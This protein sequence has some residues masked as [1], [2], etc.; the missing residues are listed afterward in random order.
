MARTALALLTMLAV[1]VTGGFSGGAAPPRAHADP[2]RSA[3]RVALDVAYAPGSDLALDIYRPLTLTRPAAGV[4]LVHGGAWRHGSKRRMSG[5]AR[6]LARRGFAVFNLEYTLASSERPGFRRQPQD[7]QAALRWIRRHAQRLDVDPRRIGA[8]GSSAGGHLVALLATAADRPLAPAP[9]EAAVVWSAPLDLARF[10]GGWLDGAVETFIGC[11]GACLGR[12]GAASPVNH[13][14]PGDAP[15]LLVNSAHEPVPAAQAETMAE[16][17]RVAQVPHR[18]RIL[19]GSRHGIEY[20]REM[21]G[22]SAAFLKRALRPR[23]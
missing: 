4:M 16:R 17:L 23:R 3:I 7:L 15:M 2:Q 18:L 1:A 20:A 9:I 5:I 21:V 6:A 14:T 19:D 12:R 22:P 13:V 10:R 11:T 8:L